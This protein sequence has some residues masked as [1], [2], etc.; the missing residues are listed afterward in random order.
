MLAP[1]RVRMPAPVL[2]RPP[3]VLAPVEATETAA[4][5][6]PPPTRL[7]VAVPAITPG[8]VMTTLVSLPKVA[9]V[10]SVSTTA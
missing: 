8:L 4:P 9:E 5:V 3:E 2:V 6:P 7:T 1:E 10:E